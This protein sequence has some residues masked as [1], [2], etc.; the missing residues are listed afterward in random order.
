MTTRVLVAD[1]HAD[2]RRAARTVVEATM[3]FEVVGE[4]ASG[5]EALALVERLSPNLVLM[6]VRMPGIGGIAA[7]RVLAAS[8]PQITTIL[9]STYAA[10][11][12]PAQ[13]LTCGAAGYLPKAELGPRAL[14]TVYCSAR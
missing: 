8:R 14:R 4:A 10:K 12:V 9:L 3:G 1:D 13:A 7:A 11:D 6:D 5:E 2:F